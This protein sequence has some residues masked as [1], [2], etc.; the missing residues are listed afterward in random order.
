MSIHLSIMAKE[1]LAPDLNVNLWDEKF[2]RDGVDRSRFSM[3][4]YYPY[5]AGIKKS[6]YEF[7]KILENFYITTWR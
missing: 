1:S 7:L 2:D 5:L 4:F 6:K 3:D